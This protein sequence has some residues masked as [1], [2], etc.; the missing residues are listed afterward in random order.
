M[1]KLYYIRPIFTEVNR[2]FYLIEGETARGIRVIL[3]RT[4]GLEFHNFI[5]IDDEVFESDI[6]NVTDT[7]FDIIFPS[8]SKGIHKGEF[9][10]KENGEILKS[11]IYQINCKESIISSESS[12]LKKIDAD[13]LLLK[14]SKLLDGVGDI[15]GKEY[16]DGRLVD[17]VKNNLIDDSRPLLRGL[18]YESE[19]TTIYCVGFLKEGLKKGE[20]ITISYGGKFR[21]P[22]NFY[23]FAV[24][25]SSRELFDHKSGD[26]IISQDELNQIKWRNLEN[27]NFNVFFQ[28]FQY[29]PGQYFSAGEEDHQALINSKAST[30]V[31]I[32]EDYNGRKL[33][34][35]MGLRGSIANTFTLDKLKIEYGESSTENSVR[36]GDLESLKFDLIDAVNTAIERKIDKS[37]IV[38]NLEDGGANKVLS[39][40]QG[41]ILHESIK[42][43]NTGGTTMLKTT[44][45]L[46]PDDFVYEI[47]K[48]ASASLDVYV[49]KDIKPEIIPNLVNTGT[50]VIPYKEITEAHGNTAST[51]PWIIELDPGFLKNICSKHK[52]YIESIFF[53]TSINEINLENL[54]P[55]CIKDICFLD[56]YTPIKIRGQAFSECP[57]HEIILPGG[58]RV[59]KGAFPEGTKIRLFDG[60]QF[61][62][63]EAEENI[64]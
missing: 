4:S 43:L 20:K 61:T 26:Y 53:Q 56:Y 30:T 60:A 32:T 62:D 11:G 17:C 13:D 24:W 35:Y 44:S 47:K 51:S 50:L 10:I 45:N 14:I 63:Y 54:M 22:D 5:K 28:D 41:K 9:L 38:N 19:Q 23:S 8:L 46:S 42:N 58:S 57:I 6:T 31:T 36:Y 49:L 55:P 48:G 12:K 15:P 3:D 59:Q 27:G 52:I 37:N 18:T 21:K 7:S 34:I 25:C 16:I 33:P 29:I 64:D 1:K 39:A 40:E 2:N